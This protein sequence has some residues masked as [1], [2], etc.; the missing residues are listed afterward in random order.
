MSKNV[1]D[2]EDLDAD[3]ARID[4]IGGPR[5]LVALP[6]RLGDGVEHAV[7]ALQDQHPR[8]RSLGARSSCR[9]RPALAAAV[10]DAA[11][12]RPVRLRHRRAAHAARARR[13]RPARPSGSGRPLQPL[14]GARASLRV[15]ADPIAPHVAPRAVLRDDTAT[16]ASTATAGRSSPATSPAPPF[17]DHE[18]ELYDLAPDRTE[19]RDLAAAQPE[20]VAELAAAWEA[21]ARAN[22]VYP[23]RR[24]LG[25]PLP[26][27]P[28]VRGRRTARRCGCCA[29]THTLERYRSQLLIQWRSFT[30]DVELSLPLGRPGRPRGPRRPGRRL[31]ALR[32][33]ERR[34]RLRPQ[35]LRHD[36]R[37]AGRAGARRLPT[38]S[39]CRSTAPGGW[40]WDVA[41]DGRRPPARRRS[42]AWSCRAPWHRSRASTSGSTAARPCHGTCTS[43]TGPFAFTG[44]LIAVTYTPGELAPDAGP[45][46]IDLVREIGARYE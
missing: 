10:G 45:R 22:Q 27:P 13:R 40:Q 18:W 16:A 29:G 23:A 20:R 6:A 12:P 17:G 9:G 2:I 24:G 37:A 14:T 1:T 36:D 38:P 35:R 34:A 3:L 5:T 43:G 31:R 30:V 11:L 32:R 46:F 8:R 4:L 26:H 33:R 42:R 7:P 41:L 19:M 21:A 15:L 25:A 44:E 39:A 28:A